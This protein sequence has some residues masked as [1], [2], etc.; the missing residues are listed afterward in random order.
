MKK[1][2]RP[3]MC[4][5]LRLKVFGVDNKTHTARMLKPRKRGSYWKDDGVDKI[6]HQVATDLETR[7]PQYE[8][9]LVQVGAFAFNFVFVGTREVPAEGVEDGAPEVGVQ[10]GE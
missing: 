3:K 7:F 5:T 6:L 9:K 2:P 10:G 8:Y 1:L 4:T